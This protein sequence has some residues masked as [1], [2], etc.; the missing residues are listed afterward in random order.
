MQTKLVFSSPSYYE[1][2]ALVIVQI[3]D[4]QFLAD[5]HI[6]ES[7]KSKKHKISLVPVSSLVIMLVCES[8]ETISFGQ[9]VVKTSSQ[10]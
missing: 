5:L 7:E 4:F 6:L 10:F 1:W 3:F 9:I 8:V 2:G